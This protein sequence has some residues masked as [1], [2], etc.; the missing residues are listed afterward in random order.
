M[1]LE[2]W[3]L[4][5]D[6]KASCRFVDLT[7]AFE[8]GIPHAPDMPDEIRTVLFDFEP[9]GFMA[10]RY[11]HVGQWGTHAD[12]PVHFAKNGRFL[13]EIDVVD[14][15]LPLVVIDISDTVSTDPDYGATI[16]D[17]QK[18]EKCN[19]EIPDHAF[20]AL[21]TDWSYRWPDSD[22]LANR[23]ELGIQHTPGWTVEALKFLCGK[24]NIIAC[25]HETAD[26]DRGIEI[27]ADLFPAET[28]VLGQDKYQIEFLKSLDQVAEVGALVVAS[29][30]KPKKGSGFPARVFAISPR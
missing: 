13:D 10:H 5:T 2:L 18:W 27:S 12:A 1:P 22:R 28:Y 25:G 19:G 30:P 15:V 14:M 16:E 26:T 21:R 4:L 11:D 20:V 24:R 29:F 23:D 17:I 6:I 8:P 7:H 3:D 9:D